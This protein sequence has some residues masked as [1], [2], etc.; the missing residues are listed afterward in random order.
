MFVSHVL[1]IVSSVLVNGYEAES[2]K[3]KVEK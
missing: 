1:K 2:H 3:Q